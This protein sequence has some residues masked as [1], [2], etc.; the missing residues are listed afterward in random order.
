MERA[1]IGEE[2]DFEQ[3]Q[4]MLIRNFDTD[5]DY[6]DDFMLNNRSITEMHRI[7]VREQKRCALCITDNTPTSPSLYCV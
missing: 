5:Q 2:P 6:E 4:R 7:G 3:V 1:H